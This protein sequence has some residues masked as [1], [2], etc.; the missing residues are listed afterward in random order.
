MWVSFNTALD[1][2]EKGNEEGPIQPK[3]IRE[4]VRKLRAKG[5][6]INTKYKKKMF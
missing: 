1:V 4:A 2:M 6:I 5:T 3:H